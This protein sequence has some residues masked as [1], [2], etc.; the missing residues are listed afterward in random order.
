MRAKKMLAGLLTVVMAASLTACGSSSQGT[1]SGTTETS[2]TGTTSETTEEQASK[3]TSKGDLPDKKLTIGAKA[4]TNRLDPMY[5]ADQEGFTYA[6]M[7]YD[8]LVESDH[9]GNYEPSLAESWE[10]DDAGTTWTFHLREGVKF[11]NGQD[12]TSA[13]V[14]CSYQRVLDDPTCNMYVDHWNTLESVNAV[15]DYTVEITT[16]EPFAMML[17]SVGWT[18]IIPHEAYEEYGDALFSEHRD[19]QC[20]TGPWELTEYNEGQNWTVSKYADCWKTNDSYYDEVEFRALNEPAT[21]ISAHLAGDIQV[22]MNLSE[23]MLSMYDGTSDRITINPETAESVFYYCQ[24]NCNEGEVFSDPNL[25]LAFD[26]AID[27][28]AIIDGYYADRNDG[29]PNGLFCT[30]TFGYDESYPAYEYDP[31]KAKELVEASDYDGTEIVLNVK[32]SEAY[33]Q[34]VGLAIVE[35]LNAVGFNASVEPIE[36]A[37]MN[38]IRAEGDYDIFM[39]TQI[40]ADGDAYS[41]LTKRVLLDA[42]HSGYVD[43]ELNSLITQ[44]NQ[45]LDTDARADLLHQINEKMR[46]TPAN[47]SNIVVY[48][49]KTAIDNG[50]INLPVYQ[51]EVHYYRYVTYEAE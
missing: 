40:H 24:F 7:V 5:I 22:N 14:V 48:Y 12:F 4:I 29:I 38:T 20:G 32:T 39:V 9:S 3:S 35:N 34:E 2:E 18:W 13:D 50:I 28:Q 23:E 37:T 44:A 36:P 49:D 30:Q 43:E 25:R 6:Y 27:R 17:A 10:V 33:A 15:D 42:H 19:I 45:E 46:E 51:D 31:E 1:D 41:H 21:A 11:Q 47:Q 8:C 26:Y 16:S